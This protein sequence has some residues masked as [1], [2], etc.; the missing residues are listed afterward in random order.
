MRA[1]PCYGAGEHTI[2]STLELHSRITVETRLLSFSSSV[3]FSRPFVC[4]ANQQRIS[5]EGA[6]RASSTANPPYN[7]N[8]ALIFHGTMIMVLGVSVFFVRARQARRE[9]DET[10]AAENAV[11]MVSSQ[12]WKNQ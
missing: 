7:M 10:M 11:P 12:Y 1:R 6:L 8:N 5:V 3:C 2:H 9:L 4:Y